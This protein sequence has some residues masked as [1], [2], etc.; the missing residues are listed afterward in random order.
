VN[1]AL[2]RAGTLMVRVGKD[3]IEVRSLDGGE[4]VALEA[5]VT[6]VVRLKPGLYLVG[7]ET[8][9]IRAGETSHVD[10]AR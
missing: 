3:E 5:G 4:S 7:D 8:V 6:R 10:L 9:E 2:E 1:A